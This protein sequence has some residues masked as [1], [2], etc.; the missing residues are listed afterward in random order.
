MKNMIIKNQ[1]NIINNIKS[2][3]LQNVEDDIEKA[4]VMPTYTKKQ[5]KDGW[6]IKLEDGKM[7][8]MKPQP[9][10]TQN[11][12][13]TEDTIKTPG[14]KPKEKVENQKEEQQKPTSEKTK[15]LM[16]K[17]TQQVVDVV[18]SD[19]SLIEKITSLTKMG[20]T[21]EETLVA[22]NPDAKLSE[23]MKM[24]ESSNIQEKVSPETQQ[25]VVDKVQETNPL[26][27]KADAAWE[28]YEMN[29]EIVLDGEKR[30]AWAYGP[31]GVGKT[32]TTTKVLQNYKKP[33]GNPLV[34]YDAELDPT[35]DEYDYRIYKAKMTPAALYTALYENN[36]KVVVFD[37]CDN[38]FE[39][40]ISVN[41]LKGVTD[42]SGHGKMT[43]PV[44]GK[45]KDN[46]GNEMPKEFTFTGKII[47][48]SNMK[49]E[50]IMK[51]RDLSALYTRA[52]PTNLE[53]T[54]DETLSQLDKIKFNMPFENANGEIFDVSK[55]DRQAA[56]DFIKEYKDQIDLSK[57]NARTMGAIALIK[58]KKDQNPDRFKNFTW[59]QA[60]YMNL[61]A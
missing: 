23:I 48:I 14:N 6:Y 52:L 56:F 1:F 50:T 60:A 33:D 53:M 45:L 4:E 12:I 40:Q 29:L 54:P 16:N 49:R 27:M 26:R 51:N 55:E 13:L 46:E 22:L 24:K 8:K 21:D 19:K 10:E 35:P 30:L 32:Y 7:H 15:I 39:D 42:T 59:Q 58:R 18:K 31:G 41:M 17:I 5:Y 36:G 20:F 28:S 44:S 2:S 34:E 9:G 47:M 61:T 57:I 25:M 38:V 3:I 11:Q 37:D 43:Y